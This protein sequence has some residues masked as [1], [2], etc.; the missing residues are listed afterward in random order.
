MKQ[1][2]WK[3]LSF[4]KFK[5]YNLGCT[6]TVLNIKYMNNLWVLKKIYLMHTNSSE[7][8][9][10]AS[11]MSCTIQVINI[12]GIK[13]IDFLFLLLVDTKKAYP[14]WLWL[15]TDQEVT[16]RSVGVIYSNYFRLRVLWQ[17]S[18]DSEDVFPAEDAEHW[19]RWTAF[20]SL[21]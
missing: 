19:K 20:L 4:E 5:S 12:T 6:R 15:V 3:G 17:K 1:G 18:A 11:L 9:Y 2:S 13:D 14:S 8:L 16:L 7:P 21:V 10:T